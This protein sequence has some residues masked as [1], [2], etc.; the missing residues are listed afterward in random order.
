[1]PE[2]PQWRPLEELG[3]AVS[4]GH[5]QGRIVGIVA[6]RA[7]V[8]SGWA[9]RAAVSLAEAWSSAGEKVV[10]VDGSLQRPALHAVLGVENGEG[11]SDAALFGASVGRI[12][13]EG[14]GGF[15]LI[16]AGT[17]VADTNA[18]TQSSR[19]SQL[20][21]SFL[22]AGVTL[23]VFLPDGESETKAFLVSAS[24]I[25]VLA[26]PDEELPR[27]VHDR[28]SLV[29]LVTGHGGAAAVG[30][31]PVTVAAPEAGALSEAGPLSTAS[32]KK[33]A[34]AG[35]GRM[36][37]LVLLALI[38]VAFLAAVFGLVDIPGI[39]PTAADGA[40]VSG[41]LTQLTSPA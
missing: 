36:Y 7:A 31:A 37:L 10:L 3:A 12:A 34:A 22:E 30:S 19:W 11:L 17:A 32:L 15:F 16:T 13:R 14:D 1:M 25:V 41:L 23:G 8:A 9:E 35:R 28:E 24:E 4:G 21:D 2:L 40:A 5:E 20:K 27:S 6:T 38:L 18:V 39:T 33:T 26:G 29:T